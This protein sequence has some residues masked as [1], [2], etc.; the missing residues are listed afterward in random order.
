MGKWVIS[1]RARRAPKIDIHVDIKP[2]SDQI[3]RRT[4]L[5]AVR[6]LR[7]STIQ[8]WPPAL[9]LLHVFSFF[10]KSHFI[11]R[12]ERIGLEA[13]RVPEGRRNEG[14]YNMNNEVQ[15]LSHRRESILRNITS[16]LASCSGYMLPDCRSDIA[17]NRYQT[18]GGRIRGN[19]CTGEWYV[20]RT[21]STDDNVTSTNR[22]RRAI[23]GT[24]GGKE[25]RK[26][27][28]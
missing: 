27:Y 4:Y 16:P 2:L 28:T 6:G 13:F 20:R 12:H 23:Q 7:P 3:E 14:K 26:R 15:H 1:Q 10:G 8:A 24:R 9:H 21:S 18:E 25:Q 19:T 22:V 17:K 5:G 11:C